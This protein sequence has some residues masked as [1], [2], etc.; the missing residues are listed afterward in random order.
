MF[1]E[2]LSKIEELD[3]SSLDQ[4]ERIGK[5]LTQILFDGTDNTKEY[6]A[7]V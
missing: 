4:V 5:K 3:R 2:S 1:E 7:R 6:Q